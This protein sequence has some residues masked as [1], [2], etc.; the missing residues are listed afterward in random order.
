MNIRKSI[1]PILLGFFVLAWLGAC[2]REF[3][4]VI[5]KGQT[6]A[7]NTVDYEKM[8]NANYISIFYD[9]RIF[10]GDELAAI[11]PHFDNIGGS[12]NNRRL[13]RLFRYE[14]KVYDSDQLPSEVTDQSGYIRRLYL[15]NK[16]IHEVMESKGGTEGEKQ[17]ILAEAKVG[18]A[19]CNFMF[20]EDFTLPY[21]VRTAS[22]ELGIPHITIADVT[23]ND[24]TRQTLEQSYAFVIQDLTE[25][26]PHLGPVT[27]RRKVS[28]TVAEFYLARIYMAMN[29]YAAAAPHIENAFSE[30]ANAT[31]PLGLYDYTIVL[32]PANTGMPGSWYPDSGFGLDNEPFAADNIQVVFNIASGWFQFQA[33]DAFAYTPETAALYAPTDYRL[34]VYTP[35]EIFSTISR[36][37]GMRR[38]NTGFFTGTDVGPSLPDMYLM[39]AEI[40]AR[41]GNLSGAVSD[42]ETLRAK[43]ITGSDMQV[44]SA[45][46]G[47]QQALVR[48]I[49]DERIREFAITGLRWSD[50][51]RLSQDPIYFDHVDYVHEIYNQSGEVESTYT[52]QP[53]RFALKF[54]QRMLNES[55]GLEENN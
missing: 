17:Q 24:F 14:E 35:F 23:Q 12:E 45:V 21:H 38:R 31:V 54:G 11:Q 47:D 48:F 46:A 20:L 27:H 28:R 25:S 19:I 51:R 44:P 7:V 1:I 55:N 32:D 41:S 53:E 37:H 50:M 9:A 52:L 16:I 29:D 10:R 3:L 49:L 15:Y 42:L 22:N 18:R 40:R 39:R 8:L 13:Q 43:R 36:P 5:P 33:V 6:V 34:N 2:K 30:L 26:L 4:E